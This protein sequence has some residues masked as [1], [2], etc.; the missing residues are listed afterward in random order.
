MPGAS[1]SSPARERRRCRPAGGLARRLPFRHALDQGRGARCLGRCERP[2]LRSLRLLR[3]WRVDGR[4]RGQ[5]DLALARGTL[6]VMAPSSPGR[7]ILVG[8]SMGGWLALLAAR[9][10][11]RRE[12]ARAPAGLVL[13]APATDFTERLMWEQFPEDIRRTIETAGFISG[14]RLF[15]RALP[16]HPPADRGRTAPPAPRRDDPNRLPG[17]HPAGHARPRRAL[18]P[19]ARARRASAGRQRL[20]DA[21]QGRRPSAVAARG[22][23]PAD[24]GGRGRGADR[25]PERQPKLL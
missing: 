1:P 25:E 13:I 19:C 5:H 23:R 4:I 16:D 7:P 20:A 15:R 24:R 12:P 2:R 3:P 22:H 14:L 9:D 21:D 18:A 6:A 17:P 11:M 10:L 8:S